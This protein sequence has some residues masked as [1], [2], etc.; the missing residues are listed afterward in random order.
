MRKIKHLIVSIAF[1][2]PQKCF[3]DT[4]VTNPP[5]VF[6][7]EQD[8]ELNL[9]I[10]SL[11]LAKSSL[12]F[13]FGCWASMA[14]LGYFYANF[15]LA[16]PL[17]IETA[18]IFYLM[19]LNFAPEDSTKVW[20]D[21]LFYMVLTD[22]CSVLP[23]FYIINFILT[24]NLR[25]FVSWISV[26]SIFILKKKIWEPNFDILSMQLTLDNVVNIFCIIAFFIPTIA[27]L[28]GNTLYPLILPQVEFIAI[29]IGLLLFGFWII[30]N[31]FTHTHPNI[32]S[33][34]K[35]LLTDAFS[36][37]CSLD[38]LKQKLNSKECMDC[39]EV[40][41]FLLIKGVIDKGVATK[42]TQAFVRTYFKQLSGEL[43]SQISVSVSY[44][45]NKALDRPADMPAE[46]AAMDKLGS[47]FK[48]LTDGA[49]PL[50]LIALQN[51]ALENLDIFD[52][53]T[54]PFKEILTTQATITKRGKTTPGA[55]LEDCERSNPDIFL[56]SESEVEVKVTLELAKDKG[57]VSN[58]LK[59]ASIKLDGGPKKPLI[60]VL[61]D[62][63][64]D[65]EICDLS[66]AMSE[67][68]KIRSHTQDDLDKMYRFY[69]M[70]K[71]SDIYNHEQK[72]QILGKIIRRYAEHVN[73]LLLHVNTKRDMWFVL[74]HKETALPP[75]KGSEVR[76]RHFTG[77]ISAKVQ[78][79]I[80]QN[81]PDTGQPLDASQSNYLYLLEAFRETQKDEN[82]KEYCS[83]YIEACKV[84]DDGFCVSFD[85]VLKI[86]KAFDNAKG[87]T[88]D[89]V[90]V[91][92]KDPDD[93][94]SMVNRTYGD[95]FD[96]ESILPV[97]LCIY[98]FLCNEAQTPG[99]VAITQIKYL[100]FIISLLAPENIE[101]L[102]QIPQDFASLKNE[103]SQE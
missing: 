65:K 7:S 28:R 95:I 62:F 66:I 3:F 33:I 15:A 24:P 55:A 86:G 87:T 30:A 48:N 72:D 13:A 6:S 77:D 31:L 36:E 45:L 20:S 64:R 100:R 38:D 39:K 83:A 50:D 21:T 70:I 47:D 96:K 57:Q 54:G 78:S 60:D 9:R 74:L 91:K 34:N 10:G 2:T 35:S 44:F 32:V 14:Y 26:F 40:A 67:L 17:L 90:I 46:Q 71:D 98:A 29:F 53:I 42:R 68:F 80:Q 37:Q 103:L 59:F 58:Y 94:I 82:W 1:M 18:T 19:R 52:S 61:G 41:Y 5:L 97:F 22:L 88:W 102:L 63:V 16:A 75:D 43:Q 85:F 51:F 49:G 89:S 73:P 76:A 56:I 8:F 99:S 4:K 81:P 11:C 25:I 93:L 23:L 92:A 101:K 84:K 12:Y 79:I 69:L 27:L